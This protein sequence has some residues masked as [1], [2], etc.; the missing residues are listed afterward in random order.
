MN[1][2]GTREAS[3]S[4]ERKNFRTYKTPSKTIPNPPAEI[5]K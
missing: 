1:F 2:H 5:A 3:C 4:C